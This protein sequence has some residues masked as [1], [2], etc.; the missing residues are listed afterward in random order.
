M[1]RAVSSSR[2]THAIFSR[3]FR[4]AISLLNVRI[5]FSSVLNLIVGQL[6]AEGPFG[7]VKTRQEFPPLSQSASQSV[8]QSVDHPIRQSR[9]GEETGNPSGESKEHGRSSGADM[10][11]LW[12]TLY[13]TERSNDK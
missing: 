5:F 13:C 8:S 9:L 3:V 11:S 6:L 10:H 7:R 1:K 4:A 2:R 12:W